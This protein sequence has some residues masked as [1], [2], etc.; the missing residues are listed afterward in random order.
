MGAAFV[1]AGWAWGYISSGK[2][3]LKDLQG[4]GTG[5]LVGFVMLFG[6]G[7]IL[8]FFMSESGLATIGCPELITGW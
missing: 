4:K 8:S 3:E 2:V 1:I 7:A 6:I 5:M